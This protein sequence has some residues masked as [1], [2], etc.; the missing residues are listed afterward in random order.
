VLRVASE[1][2][3]PGLEVVARLGQ[4]LLEEPMLAIGP[5]PQGDQLGTDTAERRLG[6]R[7]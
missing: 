5:F 2:I 4:R 3:K 6:R 1:S 7:I